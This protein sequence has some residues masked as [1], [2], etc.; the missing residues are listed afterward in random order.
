M[1]QPA[2]V[3]PKADSSKSSHLAGRLWRD[4][5][6]AHLGLLGFALL[7]M[8]L[9]GATTATMAKLMEPIIDK[10]FSGSN[11]SMIWPVALAVM[12][13]F[14]VRGFATYG[15]TLLMNKLGQE[16]VSDIQRR[17]FSHLIY[18]DVSFFHG[19]QSGRLLSRFLTDTA[20]I[21]TATT[22]ALVGFGKNAFTLVFLIGVMFY[23]DWKLSLIS[24]FV[25]PLAAYVVARLS[26]KLRRVSTDMQL[27]TGELTALLGQAFQGNKHVKAYGMEGFEIQRIGRAI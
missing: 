11:A 6:R 4:F 5:V 22:E 12:G 15:H 2:A 21:R 1:S 7:L 16:V 14:T 19:E 13:V 9:A 24:L 17:M 27:E 23:Q 10:V 18:S 25:F 3:N 20:L 26:K 8:L